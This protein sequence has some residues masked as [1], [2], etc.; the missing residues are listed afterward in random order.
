MAGGTPALSERTRHVIHQMVYAVFVP[1]FFATIGLQ[2]DFFANFD[3]LPVL[4]LTG[5]G[6]AG[7]YLGAW[8]GARMTLL[9]SEDRQTVAIAHTPGGSMEMIMAFVALQY[10]LITVPVFVAIVF[11][12]IVSSIAVGPWLAWSVRRRRTVSLLDLFLRRGAPLALRAASRD[13]AIRELCE[14]AADAPDLPHADNLAAAVRAR[15]AVAGTALEF[16]VAVPHARIPGLANP[17]IVFGRSVS[18]LEWDAPD[19]LPAHLIFLIL[20]PAAREDLQVQI[21]GGLAR[22]LH[23]EEVRCHLLAAPDEQQAQAVLREA[24]RQAEVAAK[25]R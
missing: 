11:A 13:E 12:A 7:R 20:T 21:L 1:I 10:R 6:V 19:G 5:V 24:L 4:L 17:V 15:E 2:I 23:R 22:G 9:S 25:P 3:P 14:A 8:V 16:G 18:G